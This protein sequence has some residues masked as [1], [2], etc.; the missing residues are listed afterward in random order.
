M[1]DVDL[2]V[3][4]ELQSRVMALS[5]RVGQLETGHREL[6]QRVRELGGASRPAPQAPP[7]A[8]AVPAKGARGKA[9]PAAT[10]LDQHRDRE[11][12]RILAALE[13]HGWNR[14]KA[15]EEVGM[16]RRTFYRRMT[17]FGLQ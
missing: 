1:A 6:E 2:R 16:P 4:L 9:A 7:V 12:A 8:P 13:K 3:L 17:D 10:A 11:K 14:V 15:A 5:D